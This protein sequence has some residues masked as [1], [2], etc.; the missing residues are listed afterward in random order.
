MGI[1]EVTGLPVDLVSLSRTTVSETQTRRSRYERW[2]NVEG[3]FCVSDPEGIKREA[4][5]AGG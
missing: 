4:Y 1:S 3:I 2:T 5:S